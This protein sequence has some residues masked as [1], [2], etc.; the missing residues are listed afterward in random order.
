MRAGVRVT[1]RQ[2]E[3]Y[4]AIRRRG[5]EGIQAH[6]MGNRDSVKTQIYLMRDAGIDIGSW[7]G[8]NGGY[9]IKTKLLTEGNRTVK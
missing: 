2:A 8:R 1:R 3:I 5:R 9:Y 4:D 6:E 7:S